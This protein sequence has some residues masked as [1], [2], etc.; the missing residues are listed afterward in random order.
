MHP[1]DISKKLFDIWN[2]N[3]INYC[4][5]KSNEHLLEGLAGETDL[6]VLCDSKQKEDVTRLLKECGYLQ[7]E[8]QFGSRYPFV[9][10]W[11]SCDEKTGKLIH[12]HLH[13][14]II[15]GHQG[16][17]EF[18]LP[19]GELSLST[20][21][22]EE[23][24]NV[25][26]S[27]PNL[28]IVILLSRIG[29]KSTKDKKKAARKGSYKLSEGDVR[30]IDYLKS[31]INKEKVQNIV[32]SYFGDESEHFMK[33]IYTG[34]QDS[35]WY[36]ELDKC[37]NKCLGKYSRIKGIKKA[38]YRAWYYLAIRFRKYYNK[39]ISEKYFTKKSFGSG[40]GVIIAFLGQDGAGKSTVTNEVKKWLN[41]K[42]DSRRYYLGSGDH[43]FS[44]WKK[45]T[46][47]L[48][49]KGGVLGTLQKI[50]AI[51]DLCHL[52]K[53]V[54]SLTKK[55]KK[56]AE[57]GGVAIF[58]R[59]PQVMYFGINDG[60]KIRPA[61]ENKNYP[62]LL[63]KILGRMADKE[64]KNYKRAIETKPDLVIKMILPP[65]VSIQRKPE[66]SLEAVKIKHEIIKNLKFEDSKVLTIDATMNFEEE[67][68]LV[69]NE[70]WEQL[71]KKA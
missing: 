40:K 57:K 9:E 20:R 26:I 59:Y 54:L 8:S 66:E 64:E 25:Y 5:W 71:I 10:D 21:V 51:K 23:N 47:A 1:L 16:M 38:L 31:R 37:V 3:G 53:H 44:F 7:L 61:L 13:Y 68:V 52:S 12:I 46:Q 58:D 14:E 50:C 63:M 55:A 41:W 28:E 45:M 27:D 18:T 62:K 69:H 39:Y 19:W 11:I 17:K 49:G 32:R 2:E 22:L 65:E 24:Y 15:T 36:L 43:Y 60:P 48:S 56:Y 42:V 6:D 34:V 4:H 67:L 35:A 30:E 70:F 29:L 33:L